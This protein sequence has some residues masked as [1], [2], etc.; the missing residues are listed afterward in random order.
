MKAQLL[1]NAL[2]KNYHLKFLYNNQVFERFGNNLSGQMLF[3][4]KQLLNQAQNSIGQ[5]M[6]STPICPTEICILR[7]PGSFT[8]TRVSL[9]AA[10]TLSLLWNIPLK[11][12]TVMECIATDPAYNQAS[13]I[14][15]TGTQK[16][17]VYHMSTGTHELLKISEI[18]FSKPWMSSMELLY[19]PG[20]DSKTIDQTHRIKMPCLTDLLPPACEHTTV[21]DDPQPYYS[22]QPIY[23][24][25]ETEINTQQK[26]LFKKAE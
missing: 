13:I 9:L 1:I 17:M 20:T 4:C 11:A 6:N 7:G 24:K 21:S 26:D 2:Y 19:I 25:T 5:E 15:E 18:D 3:D 8:S 10:K 23:L 16:K 22:V 12:V 14:I